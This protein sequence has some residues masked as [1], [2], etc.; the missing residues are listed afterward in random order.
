MEFKWGFIPQ[1]S[2]WHFYHQWHY[3]NPWLEWLRYI[4][5]SWLWLQYTTL[6]ITLDAFVDDS[7]CVSQQNSHNISNM[8]TSN[9]FMRIFLHNGS[10]CIYT[11][12]LLQCPYD[13][14]NIFRQNNGNIWVI[15]FF[16]LTL[17]PR[18][19]AYKH[20][21]LIYNPIK[22]IYL[23]AKSRGTRVNA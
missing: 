9:I 19:F 1:P 3:I 6:T 8:T 5:S 22:M 14:S 11:W 16:A 7:C 21:I 15:L 12:W 20:D 10:Q 4:I 17:V 2:I 18:D 13:N 23:Y